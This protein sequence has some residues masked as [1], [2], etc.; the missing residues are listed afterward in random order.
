MAPEDLAVQDLRRRYLDCLRRPTPSSAV[1]A[2]ITRGNIL[3]GLERMS[4]LARFEG[5]ARTQTVYAQ[6]EAEQG[7]RDVC[8]V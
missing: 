3:Y 8:R 5:P 4:W 6:P 1:V 2:I 7:Q